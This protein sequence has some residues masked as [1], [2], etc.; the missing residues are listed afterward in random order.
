[1]AA[2]RTHAMAAAD[3]EAASSVSAPCSTPILGD[4]RNRA[5][6]F[7]RAVA[8]IVGASSEGRQ[9][10]ENA[11]RMQFSRLIDAE[12]RVLACF[13]S[14][15]DRSSKAR[16]DEQLRHVQRSS[17]V[18]EV[19]L[20]DQLCRLKAGCMNMASSI[21]DRRLQSLVLLGFRLWR[22]SVDCE[23]QHALATGL[24][25]QL[26]EAL[27]SSAKARG[28]SSKRQASRENEPPQNGEVAVA[29]AIK[30][31]SGHVQ[32]QHTPVIGAPGQTRSGERPVLQEPI[33]V[34]PQHGLQGQ[35][36]SH[37]ASAPDL[38]PP[39]VQQALMAR[40]RTNTGSISTTTSDLP[41]PC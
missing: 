30:P 39:A 15:R 18:K 28:K 20:R 5:H 7:D 31:F 36:A 13:F 22:A 24:Q 16:L 6:D 21:P 1:M 33:E 34:Q 10:L 25:K 14:Q 4:H 32:R 17:Q 19:G 23:R 35:A 12:E 3:I 2:A 27:S 11:V 37:A 29:D 38:L 9:S 41:L 8:T 40:M 26:Q